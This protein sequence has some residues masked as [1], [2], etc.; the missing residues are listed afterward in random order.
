MM[1]W[2]Q[3]TPAEAVG[4][5]RGQDPRTKSAELFEQIA[6]HCSKQQIIQPCL[7]PP[8][9]CSHLKLLSI[10]VTSYRNRIKSWINLANQH[11]EQQHKGLLRAIV[12]SCSGSGPSPQVLYCQMLH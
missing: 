1:Q 10:Y 12:S 9:C 11:I 6:N 8:V 2:A 4:C 3:V 5:V 7:P